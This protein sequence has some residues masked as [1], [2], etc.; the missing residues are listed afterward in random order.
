[1]RTFHLSS[2]SCQS[3]SLQGGRCFL[4]QKEEE[5]RGYG[6]G[7]VKRQ[8][9]THPTA[10][11][12]RTSTLSQ[13]EKWCGQAESTGVRCREGDRGL[14]PL[15]KSVSI[16]KYGPSEDPD[17]DTHS[18]VGGS[19]ADWLMQMCGVSSDN[20]KLFQSKSAIVVQP[21]LST[22][23]ILQF[24]VCTRQSTQIKIYTCSETG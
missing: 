21:A 13:G 4:W 3:R 17:T 5:R 2:P 22:A 12:E 10:S 11:E 7:G 16:S 24:S 18:L 15:P 23:G 14:P 9:T 19:R 6:G 1:M 8:V 20:V